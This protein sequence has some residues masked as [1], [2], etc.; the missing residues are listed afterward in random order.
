MST[1]T[2]FGSI[3]AFVPHRQF[4]TTNLLSFELDFFKFH[5]NAKPQSLAVL[6]I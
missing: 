2:R 5:Q 4:C 3:V 1:K 6:P